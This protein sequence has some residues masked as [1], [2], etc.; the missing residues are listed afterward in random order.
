VER[1]CAAGAL[2]IIPEIS[3]DI[4]RRQP[5]KERDQA[6]NNLAFQSCPVVFST[7]FAVLDP[8]RK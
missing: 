3:A 2:T 1:Y 8:N 4:V 5:E 7:T 6:G